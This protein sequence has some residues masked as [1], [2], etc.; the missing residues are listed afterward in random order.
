MMCKSKSLLFCCSVCFAMLNA[1]G[2]DSGSSASG[3]I[4]PVGEGY[5]SSSFVDVAESSCA[6][7]EL[8]SSSSE[9][10][11]ESSQ[12]VS[13]SSSEPYHPIVNV[14]FGSF[15]DER[16]GH[17]YKTVIIDGR[18][19]MA[20][21]LNYK[22]QGDTVI[23]VCYDNKEES[24]DMYGRLYDWKTA[25]NV[26]PEGWHLPSYLEYESLVKMVDST[27]KYDEDWDELHSMTAS[28]F[29][30]ASLGWN[31]SDDYGF[32]A[33][34]AG[35]YDSWKE[36]FYGKGEGAVFWAGTEAKDGKAYSLYLN[37]NEQM[38]VG[39]FAKTWA[40]SVRCILSSN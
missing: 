16:D 19:W 2:D 29:L 23:A 34:P 7:A 21:N 27:V 11:P 18:T 6:I 33:L 40:R 31:G 8:N 14:S 15:T 26:C 39:G 5:S 28:V 35:G 4:T 9:S 17:V 1:C 13:S 22:Y 10:A 24:C 12:N 38:G 25:L 32:N 37:D 20:E 30:K 3:E 36:E